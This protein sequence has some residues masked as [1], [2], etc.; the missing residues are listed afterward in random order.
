VRTERSD[1]DPVTGL[2]TQRALHERLEAELARSRAR[3]HSLVLAMLRVEGLEALREPTHADAAERAALALAQSLRS[4][5]RDFDV[6][7]RPEPGV[8]AAIVP[9]PD[10]EVPPL[11]VSPRRTRGASAGRRR[12]WPRSAPRLRR[13]PAG[14]RQCRRARAGRPRAPRRRA[15]S[16]GHS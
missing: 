14:R 7:A 3:G 15:L 11:L 5:L 1:A 10:G 4:V 6:V 16:G 12:A 2:L 8:F 13:L 9:E